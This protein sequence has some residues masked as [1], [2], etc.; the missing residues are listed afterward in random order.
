MHCFKKRLKK[1]IQNLFLPGR[2]VTPDELDSLIAYLK[3]KRARLLRSAA[4]P[5]AGKRKSVALKN[6]FMLLKQCS[7]VCIYNLE[8][9]V[10]V[11]IHPNHP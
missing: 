7:H 1:Y 3:D 6:R 2:F 10:A 8:Y 4:D 5:L 11:I 9:L